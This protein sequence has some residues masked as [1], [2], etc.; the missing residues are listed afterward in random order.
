ML[1][2]VRSSQFKR[3]VKRVKKRNKD[4]TK[5]RRLLG[6]LIEQKP[7]PETYLDHPLRGNWKSYRDAHIE[8]DWLLIYRIEGNESQLARTGTHADLFTE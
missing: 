3:D 1:V 4:M 7:L 5:L 2:P 8:P 6:L